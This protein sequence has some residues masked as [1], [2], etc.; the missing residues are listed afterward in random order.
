MNKFVIV[1]A[2]ILAISSAQTF[3]CEENDRSA[4]KLCTDIFEPVCGI[5]QPNLQGGKP[6]R[7]TFSSH[8]NACKD[9]SV[10]FVAQGACEAYPE[11]GIFCHPNSVN[12]KMCP[13]IFSPVCGMIQNGFMLCQGGN[14][15]ETFSNGCQACAS[16]SFFYTPGECTYHIQQ[17]Q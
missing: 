17:E 2:A 15:V 14:C 1:L 7:A 8:C 5:K 6:I 9:S 3:L 4:N 11:N 12:N 16:G 10:V 13:M